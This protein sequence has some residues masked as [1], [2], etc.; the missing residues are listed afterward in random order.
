M[1]GLR[2]VSWLAAAAIAVAAPAGAQASTLPSGFTETTAISG[3]TAPTAVRFSPAGKVVV[4]EKSGVIKQFDSL[5]DTTPT[6]IGD[7]HTEVHDFWDRGLLGL[8]LDPSFDTNSRLYALYTYNKLGWPSTSCPDPPGANKDGCVVRGRL[9]MLDG[10]GEHVLI[11]DWCQQFPSHSIG[12]LAWGADG[13]LYVSAG[14]GANFISADDGQFGNPCGDPPHEGGAMRSQDLRTTG[15]PLGLSG[16]ILRL[17]PSNPAGREIVA[18]G[19]RNPFRITVR[20]GTNEIWMGDVGW[21][22]SEEIDRLASPNPAAPVNF[23][24]PCFEGPNPM[25]AYQA[26]GDSLCQTLPSA[27][28]PYWDYAHWE[29]VDPVDTCPTG[30]SSISGMAFYPAGGSFGAAYQG[31]LF[32]ED[33]TRNCIWV[34]KKG[35]DG[36]PDKAHPQ[37]FV[38]AAAGPVDLQVGP[39]GDLFYVDMLGGKIW[40]IR[41]SA[42]IADPTARATANKTSGA[43]PLTVNFDGSGSTDPR[44]ETLTYAW[45]FGDGG[46]SAQVSPSHTYQTSGVYT[47]QLTVTDMSGHRDT[48]S[49]RITAGIPPTVTIT[50]PAA[51]T[52]WVVG[53]TINFAGTAKD[54]QGNAIAPAKLSWQ[55][56]LRHCSSTNPTACHTHPLQALPGVSSGS[57]TAPDHEYPSHLELQLTATDGNGLS[58]TATLPLFPKTVPITLGSQPAGADLTLGAETLAAPFTLDIIRGSRLSITAP[59]QTTLGGAPFSFRSWSDGGARSHEIV[60][61]STAAAYTATFTALSSA[62]RLTV[63]PSSL[64]FTGFAGSSNPAPKRLTVTGPN[65]SV[66]GSAK[67]LSVARTGSVVTVSPR[68]K[69]LKRGPHHGT[70][71]V[72]S[73]GLTSVDVPVK[74]T[75]KSHNTG[76]VG[77][78]GFDETGGRTAK[79]A[80]RARNAGSISGATRTNGRHGGALAFDGINDR[81]TVA[82]AKSLDLAHMTLEAWVR[83]R[84]GGSQSAIFVKGRT[85]LRGPTLRRNRWS[86]LAI[87]WDGAVSRL[88]V[89]GKHV[90]TAP[91]A[92]KL[93]GPLRIGGN[94]ILGE[95]FRGRIDD[96]RVYNRALSAAEIAADR[97]TPVG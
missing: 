46:S 94:P 14:E 36:L 42:S 69:G 32:F 58:N 10:S 1:L 38:T 26:L 29:H 3:L 34:M 5:S 9:S 50:A 66:R 86:H 90:A 16:T 74:L 20:P 43:A 33:Y 31:A 17:N 45:N 93:R 65:I 63:T 92:V 96:V 84:R 41:G 95:W 54:S 87:T 73:P 2:R 97:H 15:D 79:D 82:D 19:L 11:D 62:P 77:A 25:S 72:S 21:N 47:A 55:I 67:W 78:W 13:K 35:S 75:V 27:T 53:D 56:N 88:Y 30:G 6:V 64:A 59:A 89:N 40:R 52:T 51:G 18:Y 83:P 81:V 24:W 70:V 28:G 80:S 60:G 39:D 8:A 85:P 61:G 68:I 12:S 76:L 57:I 71:V 44:G 4:A 22:T 48:T 37:V 91:L 49:L 23:G 7:L